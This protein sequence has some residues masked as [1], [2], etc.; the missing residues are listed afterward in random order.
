MFKRAQ[1]ILL[2]GGLS[3][4]FNQ[5]CSKDRLDPVT[6]PAIQAPRIGVEYNELFVPERAQ[7]NDGVCIIPTSSALKMGQVAI[8]ESI[9]STLLIHNTAQCGAAEGQDPCGYCTLIVGPRPTYHNQGIGF[10]TTA[11]SQPFS[12]TQAPQLPFSIVQQKAEC[13]GNEPVEIKV[14]FQAPSVG[15]DYTTTLVIESNDPNSMV[16]EIPVSVQVRP[17]PIA[18]ATLEQEEVAPLDRIQLDG[19]Q[20]YDPFPGGTINQYH[21][22]LTHYPSHIDP[23]V[24]DWAN[25]NSAISS[26]FV[27]VAGDYTVQLTVWNDVNM[28]SLVTAESTISFTAIPESSLHVALTW[29]QPTNDMDLHLV[30]TNRSPNFCHPQADCNWKNCVANPFG[31]PVQ[32]FPSDNVGQGANPRLDIDSIHEAGPENVNVDRPNPG[33]Y[34]IYVHY[35]A[36]DD[37][38]SSTYKPENSIVNTIKVYV[39]GLESFQANRTLSQNDQIWAVGD[40]VWIDDGTLLGDGTVSPYPSDVTNEVGAVATFPPLQSCGSTGW[41]FPN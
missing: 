19:S 7:C 26:F 4:T 13:T 38:N 3:I 20:S 16:V 9:S 11:N 2:L 6:N 14:A 33:A 12:I 32:W 8:G 29:S 10:K 1:L 40:I 30:H 37:P 35:Y 25:Q 28:Q 22:E 17:A 23:S 36:W 34:R 18:I 41:V 31:V 39:N 27:P 15:G 24:F 5:G 21:W